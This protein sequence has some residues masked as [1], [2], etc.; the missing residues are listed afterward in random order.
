MTTIQLSLSR[1]WIAFLLIFALAQPFGLSYASAQS[2]EEQV[3]QEWAQLGYYI[4]YSGRVAPLT[5]KNSFGYKLS[6]LQ[7]RRVCRNTHSAIKTY[8]CLNDYVRASHTV[9]Q[10]T[11]S[12]RHAT[13]ISE[14]YF[15]YSCEREPY[16]R[17]FAF[18]D[19][20]LK[21]S[22]ADPLR[23]SVPESMR[24]AA[25]DYLSAVFKD[26]CKSHDVCYSAPWREAGWLEA[27]NL[28]AKILC[29]DDFKTDM[30]RICR[31]SWHRNGFVSYIDCSVAAEGYYSAV[32]YGGDSAWANGQSN[33]AANA[34]YTQH[35]L[36]APSTGAIS[37]AVSEI[38]GWANLEFGA[39]DP[40]SYRVDIDCYHIALSHEDTT[41]RV[42]VNFFAGT[43]FVQ[44]IYRNSLSCPSVGADP[45]FELQTPEKITHVV[46]EI[47]GDNAFF[48]DELK[49]YNGTTKTY[50]HGKDDGRGWC[51]STDPADTDGSWRNYV[52]QSGCQPSFEFAFDDG[53]GGT[54]NTRG[55]IEDAGEAV[56][57]VTEGIGSEI[58]T[59]IGRLLGRGDSREFEVTLDC[60]HTDMDNEDTKDEIRVHFYSKQKHMGTRRRNGVSCPSIGADPSFTIQSDRQISHVVV[61][62]NGSNAF[63]ID[64]MRIFQGGRKIHHAGKDNGRG[65][66]LSTDPGDGNGSWKSFV[67]KSGCKAKHIFRI[68]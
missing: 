36:K 11:E 54:Q 46:I 51:L 27:S 34:C 63:F 7:A 66:C 68:D 64:E 35:V 37:N 59:E 67:S 58:S 52:S 17:S 13:S 44:G 15:Q 20:P 65:W 39:S 62:T 38:G 10:A 19:S 1:F 21:F 16:T 61:E 55:K 57:D 60:Y 56:V 6:N 30:L 45:S 32:L 25:T 48:M 22:N 41:N 9:A 3:C 18:E 40:N 29:D 42:T 53:S 28:N 49:M 8:E 24:N 43:Q 5:D 23:C 50:H 31:N 4:D 47:D 33:S 12:C 26:A 2:Y 14:T